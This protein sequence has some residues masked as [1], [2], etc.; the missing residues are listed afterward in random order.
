M[1]GKVIRA[2]VRSFVLGAKL[3]EAGVPH[4]GALVK[5]VGQS[6][7]PTLY[8]LIYDIA[9]NAG[10]DGMIR[11]VSVADEARDEDIQWHRSRVVPLEVSVLCV[12]YQE[13]GG[14]IRHSLPPQPPVTLVVIEECG[15]GDIL[16]FTE[17]HGYLRLILDARD[18]PSDELLAVCLHNAA[19][20]R[21]TEA[22]RRRYLI[23]CGRE[24]AHMLAKDSQRLEQVLRRVQSFERM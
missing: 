22:A 17:R 13:P 11:M 6:E 4:F 5:T 7:R 1:I 14:A 3:P 15:P 18:A 12:G 9:V 2:N 21:D 23:S 20:A 16:A 10:D 24:L 8:G 19:Q